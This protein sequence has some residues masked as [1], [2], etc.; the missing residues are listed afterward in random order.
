MEV[1]IVVR[2]SYTTIS[3][4]DFVKKNLSRMIQNEPIAGRAQPPAEHACLFQPVAHLFRAQLQPFTSSFQNAVYLSS[5]FSDKNLGISLVAEIKGSLDN[6]CSN[7]VQA[8][9]DLLL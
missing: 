2:Q 4:S 7:V 6:K 5:D 8:F 9:R 1:L 3:S